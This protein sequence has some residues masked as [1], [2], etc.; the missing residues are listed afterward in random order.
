[1]HCTK[2][3]SIIIL[4]SHNC[5]IHETSLSLVAI[6]L[7]IF[8]RSLK[9]KMILIS[10]LSTRHVSMLYLMN[11]QRL[12]NLLKLL[13]CN[14]WQRWLITLYKD[15]LL[16]WSAFVK[17]TRGKPVISIKISARKIKFHS[18]TLQ[19]R[20]SLCIVLLHSY[21]IY[22]INAIYYLFIVYFS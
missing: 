6:G 12:Q 11:N 22:T 7:Y 10:I 4:F 18:L 20:L 14:V 9:A 19:V 16:E 3:Q 21:N 1:M 5:G 17:L 8:Y 2:I 13:L 15:D